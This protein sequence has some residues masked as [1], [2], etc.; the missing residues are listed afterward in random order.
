MCSTRLIDTREQIN[1]CNT[2]KRTQILCPNSLELEPFE[3]RISAQN[4]RID[5]L[6]NCRD[7][8]YAHA[9][10]ENLDKNSD[11]HYTLFVNDIDSILNIC[12]D[13]INAVSKIVNGYVIGG[14]DCKNHNPKLNYTDLALCDL[15]KFLNVFSL[16]D[17]MLKDIR[18]QYQKNSN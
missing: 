3:S 16:H 13:G 18:Q 8:H 5:R 12:F 6:C 4:E 1:L 11:I 9:D 14:Y 17:A 10:I 15:E 2:I 7:K